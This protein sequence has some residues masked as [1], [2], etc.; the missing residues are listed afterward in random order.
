MND[1]PQ[2]P[3]PPTSVSSIPSPS[4]TPPL[5]ASPA[6]FEPPAVPI[7]KIADPAA[8]SSG[9]L[10]QPGAADLAKFPP[11]PPLPSIPVVPAATPERPSSEIA[12]ETATPLPGSTPGMPMY[13]SGDAL[14]GLGMALQP[15]TSGRVEAIDVPPAPPQPKKFHE[16]GERTQA[17]LMAGWRAKNPG[18]EFPTDW[19]EPISAPPTGSHNPS[20]PRSEPEYD[21][22]V[23]VDKKQVKVSQ[24]TLDEMNAGRERIAAIATETKRIKD[25]VAKQNAAAIAAD[26]PAQASDMDYVEGR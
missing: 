18:K 3:A 16:L 25:L 6:V 12:P 4:M 23:E 13:P 9:L 24:R 15:D 26:R 8:Q 14:R 20:A 21:A 17:E 2:P 19:V 10:K 5:P 22:V 1:V 7:G 11:P